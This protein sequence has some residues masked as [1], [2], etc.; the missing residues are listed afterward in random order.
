ME[1]PGEDEA[2]RDPQGAIERIGSEQG[3]GGEEDRGDEG[4]QELGHRRAAH[5]ARHH[6]GQHDRRAA[7]QRGEEPKADERV[8]KEPVAQGGEHG[9]QHRKVD[10]AEVEMPAGDHEVQL[11]AEVVIA[12]ADDDPEDQRDQGE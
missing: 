4:G 3:V 1:H 11:V 10:V 5:L 7:R 9:R 2:P 12:A 6:G 8:A